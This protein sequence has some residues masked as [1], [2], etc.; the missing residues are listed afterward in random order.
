MMLFERNKYYPY[1]YA[2]LPFRLCRFL[3]LGQISQVLGSTKVNLYDQKPFSPR[4]NIKGELK[5]KVHSRK[6]NCYD[7]ESHVRSAWKQLCHVW[8]RSYHLLGL[9]VN[10]RDYQWFNQQWTR[11]FFFSRLFSVH[12]VHEY[13]R[14]LS[15]ERDVRTIHWHVVDWCAN[16]RRFTLVF[17][18]FVMLC[19]SKSR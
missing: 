3:I 7:A 9:N 13:I 18:R 4:L 11:M 16:M 15:I 8:N 14:Y 5:L 6:A 17:C 12:K 19:N 2:Q 10:Q 1:V